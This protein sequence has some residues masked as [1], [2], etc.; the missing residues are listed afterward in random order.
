MSAATRQNKNRKDGNANNNAQRRS[1]VAWRGAGNNPIGPNY[2]SQSHRGGPPHGGPYNNNNSFQQR[3]MSPPQ[4]R[5][6][7]FRNSV[8]SRILV[9]TRVTRHEGVL[10]PLESENLGIVLKDVKD[11]NQPN[12]PT[13]ETLFIPYPQIIA[14]EATPQAPNGNFDTFRTDTD[15]SNATNGGNI[16]QRELQAWKPDGPDTPDSSLP[17]PTFGKTDDEATFGAAATNGS[18]DQFVVNEQLFGVTTNFDE[19]IY[20]TKLDRSAPDYKDRERKAQQIANEILGTA[21]SNPH[22][23]EERNLV[24]DSGKNEEDKYGAVVR[25]ANA[26]IPPG[27]RR[28]GVN[29]SLQ[30]PVKDASPA[31]KPEIPQVAV[32]APDGTRT[33]VKAAPAPSSGS[34]SSSAATA[35]ATAKPGADTLVG[36]FRDFVTNERQR[37]TQKKQA[38]VRSEMDKRM[39]DLIKFSQNFKLSQPIPEDLVPILTKD[40]DKQ[41]AIIMKSNLDASSVAARS[42]APTTTTTPPAAP[43][44]T[45]IRFAPTVT[46]NQKIEAPVRKAPVPAAPVKVGTPAA[47]PA[48]PDAP[49]S[50][51]IIQM[52]IQ[53]IPPFNPDKRRTIANV[54]GVSPSTQTQPTAPASPTASVTSSTSNAFRLNINASTFKP[55]PN[56]SAFNPNA[57]AFKPSGSV[58]VSAAPTTAPASPKPKPVEAINPF[59]GARPIKKTGALHIRDDFNPFKHAKVSEASAVASIWPYNG[60]RYAAMFPPTPHPPPQPQ[61]QPP[62]PTYEEDPAAQAAVAQRGGYNMMYAYPQHQYPGQ[63]PQ[64][65]IMLPPGSLPPGGY[66]SP[67]PFYGAPMPYPGMPPAGTPMYGPPQLSSMPPTQPYMPPP[68]PG[69][70]QTNGAPPRGSLPP[71]AMPPHAYYHQS[72]QLAHA[73]PYPMM[74]QQGGPGA[75]PHPYDG[76]GPPGPGP[77]SVGH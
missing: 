6:Q 48:K 23:A 54:N 7:F 17:A 33:E 59:F 55:N 45:T 57:S 13:Q 75:P 32:N 39:A 27:A 36:S 58:P 52:K 25:G 46:T 15:I 41:K 29:G 71:A 24:D 77:M 40:E 56:A 42:I 19:E 30:P 8:G 44:T 68:P 63:P 3:P 43:P 65:P 34:P 53:Q 18:W 26:Y 9:H 67:G 12:A 74:M 21:S 10:A 37:L 31:P 70:Y 69:A 47:K 35:S 51:P 49:P 73:V 14:Q 16:R 2:N 11:L 72:P 76:Q 22:I 4:E 62:P 61:S 28:N 38:I 64:Q 1:G 50:R 20:T 66:M 5:L 60:K